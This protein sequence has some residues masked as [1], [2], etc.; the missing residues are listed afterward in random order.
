V[1]GF[2]RELATCRPHVLGVSSSP[3]CSA[4]GLFLRDPCFPFTFINSIHAMFL[5]GGET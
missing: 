5:E 3:L 4:H 2:R 1:L